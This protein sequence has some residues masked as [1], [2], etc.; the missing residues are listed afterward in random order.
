MV[1]GACPCREVGAV[2]NEKVVPKVAWVEQ[3]QG[4]CMWNPG[5][6]KMVAGITPKSDSDELPG[7]VHS[8][9]MDFPC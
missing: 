1:G 5:I 7:S 6:P 2:R 8:E 3:G 4:C 9:F